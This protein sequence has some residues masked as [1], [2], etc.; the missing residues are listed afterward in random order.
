MSPHSLGD[1][2]AREV[3]ARPFGPD[4]PDTS[5]AWPA[6][7]AADASVVTSLAH[8]GQVATTVLSSSEMPALRTAAGRYPPDD[9]VT[10]VPTGI[11]TTM[12]VLLADSEITKKLGSATVGLVGEARSSAS[13]RTS[14]RRPR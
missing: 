8:D 4:A 5:I 1:S 12:N 14:S 11:G 2:E 6:D 3:L 7:G 13:S 10:S 9:A